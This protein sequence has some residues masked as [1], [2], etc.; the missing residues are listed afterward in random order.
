MDTSLDF[1]ARLYPDIHLSVV[2]S[3]EQNPS[4]DPLRKELA[5]ILILPSTVQS[6]HYIEHHHWSDYYVLVCAR[7]G[8]PSV[9]S[10]T[11]LSQTVRYVAW[12]HPG[13]ERLHNHLASAQLRLSHRG[14]LSCLE[15]LLDLIAKGHC[16]SILPSALLAGRFNN[17]EPVPLP[18]MIMRHISVVARPTSLLSNAANAVLQTL[19]KPSII[20]VQR[21]AT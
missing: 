17:L 9:H 13:L 11:E 12:R 3:N 6:E 21:L 8:H 7:N 18:L 20:S 15:T 1:L 14:E 4:L 16:I 19:K 10:F 5:D 2:H